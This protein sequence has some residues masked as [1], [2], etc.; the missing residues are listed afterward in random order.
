MLQDKKGPFS[1]RHTKITLPKTKQGYREERQ[2]AVLHKGN[3]QSASEIWALPVIQAVL[4]FP[5]VFFK[6]ALHYYHATVNI[7][8]ELTLWMFQEKNVANG[9][10]YVLTLWPAHAGGLPTH[11][12]TLRCVLGRM[13][14]VMQGDRAQRSS[15]CGL[16]LELYWHPLT[17]AH[18]L[19]A[20][21]GSRK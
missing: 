2:R 21:T 14:D 8:K 4:T 11:P 12:R 6:S 3:I 13:G 17:M 20:L 18:L 7:K 19:L 15:T 16:D 5:V 1:R 10:K 9:I